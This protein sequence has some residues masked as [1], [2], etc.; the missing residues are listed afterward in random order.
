MHQHLV[1]GEGSIDFRGIFEALRAVD[2]GG[3]VTVELYPYVANA[4]ESGRQ[5]LE[6]LRPLV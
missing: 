6:F 1:P 5:A 4:E 3:W 2:Y